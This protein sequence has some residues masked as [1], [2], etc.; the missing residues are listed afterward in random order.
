[1][2]FTLTTVVGSVGTIAAL[3]AAI[4]W[5]WASLVHVP[6]NVDTFIAALQWASRLNSYGAMA[7]SVAAICGMI[8]LWFGRHPVYYAGT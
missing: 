8:V 4:F 3:L 6:D 5:L 2:S 1:M 7:A